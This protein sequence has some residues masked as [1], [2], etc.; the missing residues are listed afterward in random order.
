MPGLTSIH[1]FVRQFWEGC[2]LVSDQCPVGAEHFVIGVWRAT[3]GL[4]T[5][6]LSQRIAQ[7]A[8]LNLRIGRVVRAVAGGTALPWRW[9][10]LFFC[11]RLHIDLVRFIRSRQVLAL[12]SNGEI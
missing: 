10:G 1:E 2:P 4:G 7:S 6:R 5:A 8:V 11:L 12:G 3:S 9:M